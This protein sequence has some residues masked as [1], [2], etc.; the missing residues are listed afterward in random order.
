MGKLALLVRRIR[1]LHRCEA[2]QSL[3][4]YAIAIAL[5]AVTLIV[6]LLALRNGVGG[7]LNGT[8]AAVSHQASSSG[9]GQ[10]GGNPGGGGNA[11]RGPK[12]GDSSG[13]GS[14]SSGAAY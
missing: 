11:G 12:P 9:Y 3:T 14:D 5:I 1:L 7:V 10:S 4:E 6:A 13:T 8:A 2:G